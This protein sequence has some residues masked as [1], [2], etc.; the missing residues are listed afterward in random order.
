[1]TENDKDDIDIDDI[2]IA[3][4]LFRTAAIH[5]GME[6]ANFTMLGCGYTPEDT[7]KRLKEREA[8]LRKI[9]YNSIND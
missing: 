3:I 2:D 5:H 1:M 7:E 9:I 4:E 6:K 8:N